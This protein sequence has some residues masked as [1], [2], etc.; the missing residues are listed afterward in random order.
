MTLRVIGK[1][2]ISLKKK[3]KE[4]LISQDLCLKCPWV[5]FLSDF[6]LSFIFN[7]FFPPLSS[8]QIVRMTLI[9]ET[10]FFSFGDSNKAPTC[11]R[12]TTPQKPIN[13]FKSVISLCARPTG[14][15]RVPSTKDNRCD[16]KEKHKYAYLSMG[17]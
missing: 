11:H 4:M 2:F 7:F 1:Q 6:I 10:C 17:P 12:E 8:C 13:S 3:I 5:H 15:G 14:A 16:W 9:S